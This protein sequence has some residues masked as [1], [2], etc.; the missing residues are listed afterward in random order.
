MDTYNDNT[1]PDVPV[2]YC[3]A[4]EDLT[5]GPCPFASEIHDDWTPVW[6]CDTCYRNACDDIQDY[7]AGHHR[8]ICPPIHV[9]YEI[10]LSSFG[11]DP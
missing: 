9:L 2:C 8:L 4:N 6:Y 5:W 10:Y 3:G 11:H 1:N 7:G